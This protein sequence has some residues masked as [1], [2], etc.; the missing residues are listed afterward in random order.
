MQH[1]SKKKLTQQ[2]REIAIT[3]MA[4][5]LGRTFNEIQSVYDDFATPSQPERLLHIVY[6]L[7]KLAIE[8]ANK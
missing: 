2:E 1:L 8:E 3:H 6:W 5:I 4:N 7:G